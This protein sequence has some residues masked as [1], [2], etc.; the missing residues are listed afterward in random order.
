MTQPTVPGWYP[1]PA[2]EPTHRSAASTWSTEPAGFLDSS[3]SPRAETACDGYDSWIELTSSRRVR[4]RQ[5][6]IAQSRSPS[7]APAH[8]TS[9]KWSCVVVPSVF[10]ASTRTVVV[11]VTAVSLRRV[12]PTDSTSVTLA[13]VETGSNRILFQISGKTAV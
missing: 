5:S 13:F 3:V 2:V 11:I 7:A 1:D 9:R 4:W 6:S 10:V 8:F 12:E